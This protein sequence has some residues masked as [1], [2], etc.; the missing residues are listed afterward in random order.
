ME[1]NKENS[2]VDRG[3]EL[4]KNL[5]LGEEIIHEN[6]PASKDD[7]PIHMVELQKTAWDRIVEGLDILSSIAMVALTVFLA[8]FANKQWNAAEKQADAANK[9][10]EAANEQIK[11]AKAQNELVRRM[12]EEAKISNLKM[13]RVVGAYYVGGSDDVKD[14]IDLVFRNL[15]SRP[16]AIL[17]IYLRTKEGSYFR[18]IGEPDGIKLPLNIGAWSA[19]EIS[20]W[21]KKNDIEQLEDILVTDMDDNK[22]IT[23][24]T[25]H[26]QL[27]LS[28]VA[29]KAEGGQIT[30]GATHNATVRVSQNQTVQVFGDKFSISVQA[31]KFAEGNSNS[32][33]VVYATIS[34]PGDKNKTFSSVETGTCLSY[35]G[36]AIR[37]ISISNDS[38]SFFASDEKPCE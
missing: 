6:Q 14:K 7:M 11:V 29:A 28:G 23:K 20:F 9:Q 26:L 18:K 16:T 33:L 30:V 37:V 22:I 25:W 32:R 5:P 34:A 1:M 12:N 21:L 2:N 10:V 38:V 13:S 31:I 8:I 19:E 4:S 36:Y 24:Q 3:N 15:S 17:S 27:K 35:A